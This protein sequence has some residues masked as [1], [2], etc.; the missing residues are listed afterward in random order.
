MPAGVLP[1]LYI[2]GIVHTMLPMEEPARLFSALADS[3][4]LR[5]LGLLLGH[6][7][8]ACVCELVDALRLPQYEVSRQLRILRECGL[9]VGEKRGTWVYYR[10][11][12]RPPARVRSVL[13][14]LAELLA[15]ERTARADW[16][17]FQRRL[18]LREGG[19]C[20]IGYEPGR[21]FRG[22]LRVTRGRRHE[23]RGIGRTPG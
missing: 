9:V 17:R 10:T 5:I 16:G 15:E 21:S 1:W 20:V 2:C 23:Q 12:S 13:G 18:S 8:G 19:V 6:G 11:P 7:E 14:S 22:Q 4:R 3:G